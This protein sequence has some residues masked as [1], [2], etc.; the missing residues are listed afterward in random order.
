MQHFQNILGAAN[1]WELSVKAACS[2]FSEETA[3]CAGDAP[4]TSQSQAEGR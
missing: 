1:R 3:R 2:V 4:L